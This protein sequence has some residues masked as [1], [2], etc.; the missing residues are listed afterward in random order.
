MISGISPQCDLVVYL[1]PEEVDALG[2]DTLEG[3]LVKFSNP[4]K[5]GTLCLSVND[6]RSSEDG[7]FGIGVYSKDYFGKIED[8]RLELFM[9]G[10]RYRALRENGRVGTRFRL[11]DG[12]EVKIARIDDEHV[13]ERLQA[14]TLEFYRDNRERLPDSMG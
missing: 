14:E 10:P 2:I 8:F 12:S 3:V 5:Q 9:S 6:A 4:K 11:M 7:P 13:S 1:R